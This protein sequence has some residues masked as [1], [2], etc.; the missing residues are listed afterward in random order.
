MF[1]RHCLAAAVGFSILGGCNSEV[2]PTS[3]NT[4]ASENEV[5]TAPSNRPPATTS[6][7]NPDMAGE[8]ALRADTSSGSTVGGSSVYIARSTQSYA[9]GG[10]MIDIAN[11]G[12]LEVVDGCLVMN[13]NE[14]RALPIFAPDA[15]FDAANGTV[16]QKGGVL[17]LGRELSVQARVRDGSGA[18]LQ[19]RP[20]SSCPKNVISM[21]SAR[22]R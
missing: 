13:T 15:V 14:G 22:P 17:Q 3:V 4:S 9:S 2:Q 8:N 12:F 6:N 11:G 10:A 1:A 7:A 5:M 16:R 20:I 18:D 21:E 19:E